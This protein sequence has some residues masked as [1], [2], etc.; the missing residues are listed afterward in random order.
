MTEK[1]VMTIFLRDSPLEIHSK[2]YQENVMKR[3]GSYGGSL[4][5]PPYVFEKIMVGEAFAF[6]IE[7]GLAANKHRIHKLDEVVT[8]GPS[9][10]YFDLHL[11][12]ADEILDAIWHFIDAGVVKKVSN[13]I[14]QLEYQIKPYKNC[15]ISQM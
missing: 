14:L 13:M 8:W 1:S 4:V 11:P 12:I 7:D 5:P 2:L 15:L 9:G 3:G 10:Y 6:Q